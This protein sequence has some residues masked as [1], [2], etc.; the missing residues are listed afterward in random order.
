M[1]LSSSFLQ[2]TDLSTIST[3]V[4]GPVTLDSVETDLLITS[5]GSPRRARI[6]LPC[7]YNGETR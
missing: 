1:S 7:R 6:S 2:V 3:A 4:A 5:A